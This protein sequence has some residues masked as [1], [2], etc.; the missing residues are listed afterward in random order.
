MLL[1]ECLFLIPCV[2]DVH[3]LGVLFALRPLGLCVEI[4][5]KRQGSMYCKDLC[6]LYGAGYVREVS[7]RTECGR[8]SRRR[9]DGESQGR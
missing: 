2:Y 4:G 5:W 7:T 9:V 1:N 3:L 8:E 6:D